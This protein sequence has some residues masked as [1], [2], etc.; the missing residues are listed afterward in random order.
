MIRRVREYSL[1]N[2]KFH[3]TAEP[4]VL[5]WIFLLWL[6]RMNNRFSCL[7]KSKPLKQEVQPFSDTS[8]QE[9][10]ILCMSS[11]WHWLIGNYHR[12]HPGFESRWRKKFFCQ[13]IRDSGDAE[14]W[15][16]KKFYSIERSLA[17]PP[18]VTEVCANIQKC[19]EMA[20]IVLKW[21]K[22]L[23]VAFLS[24]FRRILTFLFQS[25]IFWSF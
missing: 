1:C 16:E 3:C 12:S 20:K 13:N 5:L 18:L 7:V 2:M 11:L 15:R 19:F 17:P 22:I 9:L 10:S 14:N 23:R 6:R 21:P 24:C 4:P 8:L 25:K